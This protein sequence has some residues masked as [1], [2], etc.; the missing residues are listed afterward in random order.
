MKVQEFELLDLGVMPAES[1]DKWGASMSEF[2]DSLVG[3]GNSGAE[4]VRDL[5]DQLAIMGLDGSEV[6]EH[7]REG[8]Y[9]G[10]DANTTVADLVSGDDEL[11]DVH[12]QYFVGL[13]FDDPRK[14]EEDDGAEGDED[15][16]GEEV[17]A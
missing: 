12:C 17:P 16:G 11:G 8:G 4:A 13:R 6:E 1:L 15:D 3:R 10:Q 14:E 2:T 7:M 9:M 5:L